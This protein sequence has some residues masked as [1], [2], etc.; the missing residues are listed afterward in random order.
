MDYCFAPEPL[1]IQLIH[2]NYV[3]NLLTTVLNFNTSD[4]KLDKQNY[5]Y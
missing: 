5:L 4:K 3:M 2:A 1:D